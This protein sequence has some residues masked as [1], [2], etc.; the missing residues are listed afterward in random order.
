MKQHPHGPGTKQGPKIVRYVLRGFQAALARN[1]VMTRMLKSVREKSQL[2]DKTDFQEIPGLQ[3]CV[4]GTP[5]DLSDPHNWINDYE[6]RCK[7][8]IA[9]FHLEITR[10]NAQ[11]L[12]FRL[13]CLLL[14]CTPPPFFKNNQ[15]FMSLPSRLTN[16]PA[17]GSVII[18]SSREQSRPAV[19]ECKYPK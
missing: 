4:V 7:G 15:L 13:E 10:Q 2:E 9:K 17:L 19:F 5:S 14:H 6:R 1:A 3:I 16:T 8:I 11:E 18:F 12:C